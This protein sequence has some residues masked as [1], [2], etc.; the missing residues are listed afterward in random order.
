MLVAEPR[1]ALYQVGV[2]AVVAGQAMRFWAAA[3]S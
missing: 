3:L 1:P 2:M